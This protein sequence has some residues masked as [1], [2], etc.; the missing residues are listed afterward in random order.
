MKSY[1]KNRLRWLSELGE[2]SYNKH[3]NTSHR[4]LFATQILYESTNGINLH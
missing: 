2:H 1:D 3:T 4:K